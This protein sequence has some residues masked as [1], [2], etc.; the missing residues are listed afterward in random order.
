MLI[1]KCAMYLEAFSMFQET[2]FGL[3]QALDIVQVLVVFLMTHHS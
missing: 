2:V 3:R 1:Q